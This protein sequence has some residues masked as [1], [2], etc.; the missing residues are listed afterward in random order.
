MKNESEVFMDKSKENLEIAIMAY[1]LCKY[2]A[3]ANRAYYAAFQASIALLAE[4]GYR[5]EKPEHRNIQ[6][7]FVRE[8][9]HRRKLFPAKFKSYLLELQDIR[10]RADYSVVDVSRKYATIQLQKTREFCKLI[11]KEFDLYEF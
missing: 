5:I 10:N 2:N 1:D 7:E 4:N 3:S 11:Y 8:F 6:S 9:I